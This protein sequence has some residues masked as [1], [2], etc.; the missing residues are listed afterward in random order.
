MKNF[1]KK[2]VI[3]ASSGI[4]DKILLVLLCLGA[5]VVVG[6][7]ISVPI[8]KDIIIGAGF[9]IGI[10]ALFSFFISLHPCYDFGM[11]C[12]QARI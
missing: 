4:F 2:W 1:G 12:S 5:G 9:F 10:M 7:L 6:Q 8:D 3:S 11:V